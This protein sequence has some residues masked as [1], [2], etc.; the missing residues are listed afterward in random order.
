MQT[1]VAET[2]AFVSDCLHA[3]PKA[4]II[5]SGR[6]VSHGYAAAADGFTALHVHRSLIPWTFITWATAFRL[7][8]SKRRARHRA[9]WTRAPILVEARPNA[10]WSP[11][12]VHDP[13]ASRRRF[14]ILSIVDDVWRPSQ[15]YR[16]WAV[17]W[18]AN[19]PRWSNGAASRDLIVSDNGTEF[20]SNSMLAGAE[21]QYITWHFIVPGNRP[22]RLNT[23]PDAPKDP[24]QGT[25]GGGWRWSRAPMNAMCWERFEAIRATV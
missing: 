7:T 2:A 17:E 16:S 22:W 8:M 24:P 21:E 1:P 25:F 20:T 13:F 10:R 15:T 4:G 19:W 9:V 11:D 18:R 5:R 14:R 3:L 23:V 6:L 12:F